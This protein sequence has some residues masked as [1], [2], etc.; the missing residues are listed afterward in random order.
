MTVI[1][2]KHITYELDSH[3]FEIWARNFRFNAF[4]SLEFVNSTGT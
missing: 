4:G 3:Y 1:A 2:Q